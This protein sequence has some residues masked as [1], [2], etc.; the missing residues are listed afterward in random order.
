[1]SF[2]REMT[3]RQKNKAGLKRYGI[4]GDDMETLID[5][6]VVRST[7][8]VNGKGAVMVNNYLFSSSDNGET[9]TGPHIGKPDL[10]CFFKRYHI[11]PEWITIPKK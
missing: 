1:M 5:A 2:T 9:W 10:D 3:S 8:F 6:K 4:W 11:T 7:E